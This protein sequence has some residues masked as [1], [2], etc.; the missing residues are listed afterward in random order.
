M[1]RTRAGS[2]PRCSQTSRAI[3]CV[4][5][6]TRAARLAFCWRARAQCRARARSCVCG[7]SSVL[8]SCTVSTTGPRKYG[9]AW[10]VSWY[11]LGRSRQSTAARAASA[12]AYAKGSRF[13]APRRVVEARPGANRG[14][15]RT[16]SGRRAASASSSPAMY[17]PTPVR[18]AARG[19]ALIATSS[20]PTEGVTHALV[21]T[22][23]GAHL[24]PDCL[25]A[26]LPQ[27]ARVTVLDNASEDGT[28]ELLARDFPQ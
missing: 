4:G 9:A 24:L 11:T 22:W 12:S 15:A 18:A 16:P 14:R 23:N 7:Y 17:R 1:T 27:G 19:A 26:L 10:F 8:R 6:I 28:S 3:A 2:T 5:T 20:K 25:R 13:T 21:L